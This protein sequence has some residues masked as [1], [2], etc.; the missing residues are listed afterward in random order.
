LIWEVSISNLGG[1]LTIVVPLLGSRSEER[2]LVTAASNASLVP[3]SND[4]CVWGIGEMVAG[5]GKEMLGGRSA[6]ELF[7]SADPTGITLGLNPC[8]NN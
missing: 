5:R 2:R 7:Y 6:L 1:L 4:G 3:V 8:L